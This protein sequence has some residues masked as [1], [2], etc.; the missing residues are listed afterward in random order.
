MVAEPDSVGG[1]WRPLEDRAAERCPGEKRPPGIWHSAGGRAPLSARGETRSDRSSRDPQ[2]PALDRSPLGVPENRW[3]GPT[4]AHTR[5]P[6][7]AER[8]TERMMPKNRDIS[9]T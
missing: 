9:G 3:N 1:D 4:L 8:T 6:C 2:V 7:Q 5:Q